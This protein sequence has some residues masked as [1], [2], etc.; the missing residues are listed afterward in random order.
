MNH[1]DSAMGDFIF[2]SSF[3]NFSVYLVGIKGTGLSALAELLAERGAS[4]HGSDI[5]ETFYTDAIL[6]KMNIPYYEGFDS[7]NVDP[8]TQLVIHSAAYERHSHPELISA[9]DKGIPVITYTEALGL[10][11]KNADSSG[12][13]GVHGKTTTVGMAGTIAMSLEL[14]VSVVAGGAVSSFGDRSTYIGGDKFLIAETCEYRRHFLSFSPRR[15]VIT[16]VELD[17]TDYF[18]DDQDIREAFEEFAM[19]LPDDGQLI[20]CADDPG[21]E[22][23]A[24]RMKKERPEVSSIPY[25]FQAEG[26]FKIREADELPERS[27]FKLSGSETDFILQVP[28]KHNMLNA[29]AAAALVS[30]LVR[31]WKGEC[32]AGDFERIARGLKDFHGSRRRHEIVGRAGQSLI[33]DDYAHHPTAIRTALAGLKKFYPGKTLIVDFM[34]HTFSRTEALFNQFVEAFDDADILI[35]HKIYS[36]A[37]EKQGNINGHDLYDAIKC[38]RTSVYYFE[39]VMEAL[40]F[41]LNLLKENTVFVTL[42]AGD[43]WRLGRAL[44]EAA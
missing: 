16:H 3:V 5:A 44:T 19:M 42:G 34:S 33:I 40:D 1:Y 17:H 8:S 41:C 29:A 31:T 21:A 27:R 35:L 13:A 10:L 25:G 14:P 38:K 32:T 43:N 4:V 23:V 6:K 18:K 28:G 30:E 2:P 15:L 9:M 36:S 20:F 37:R 24:A 7:N 11:S 12:V 26:P 22:Y 39:E